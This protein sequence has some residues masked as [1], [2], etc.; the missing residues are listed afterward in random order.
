MTAEDIS[1]RID[2]LEV[3]P[4]LKQ[5]DAKEVASKIDFLEVGP[6]IQHLIEKN[7]GQFAIDQD[8]GKLTI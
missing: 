1:K 4:K 7:N 6:K 5:I 2:F 3:G 8:T